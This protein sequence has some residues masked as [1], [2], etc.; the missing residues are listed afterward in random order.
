MC[1]HSESALTDLITMVRYVAFVLKL[2]QIHLTQTNHQAQQGVSTAHQGAHRVPGQ[3]DE[4]EK[5]LSD[6]LSSANSQMAILEQEVR[7]LKRKL[8]TAEIGK[9]RCLLSK[10]KPKFSCVL[11]RADAEHYPT[12]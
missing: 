3:F 7:V 9:S 11:I 5:L 4:N 10:P 1:Y 6:C 8:M 2:K 12:L